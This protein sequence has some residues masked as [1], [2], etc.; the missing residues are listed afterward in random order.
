MRTAVFRVVRE[1]IENIPPDYVF[2]PDHR[3]FQI[4]IRHGDDVKAGI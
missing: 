2:A 1:N 3:R 4:F